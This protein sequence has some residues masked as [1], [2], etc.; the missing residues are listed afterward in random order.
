[1]HT[2]PFDPKVDSVVTLAALSPYVP[3]VQERFATWYSLRTLIPENILLLEDTAGTVIGVAHILDGGLPWA[4]VDGV[5]IREDKRSL[6][7]GLA[8]LSG[9]EAELKARGLAFFTITAPNELAEVLSVR[10]GFTPAG[11]GFSF[12]VKSL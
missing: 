6:E 7:A 1:M 10:Y 4:T 9:I 2:R 3:S 12:L 8:I 5:F 11:E